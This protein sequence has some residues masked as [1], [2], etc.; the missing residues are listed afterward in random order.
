MITLST[1]TTIVGNTEKAKRVGRGFGSGKGGHTTGSGTKGQKAREG[2][3][4]NNWFE[5][6]QTPLVRRLP[7]IRGFKSKRGVKM[8]VVKL[9]D[10]AKFPEGQIIT[11][12]FL[13]KEFPKKDFEL[14]KVLGNGEVTTKIKVQG[15]MLTELSK[16]K[17]LKAGGEIL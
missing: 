16:S 17:I 1:L 11:S 4:P 13:K 14:V 15:L 8:F 5:G 10:L 3:K 2:T 7:F 9:S 6:G 12:E